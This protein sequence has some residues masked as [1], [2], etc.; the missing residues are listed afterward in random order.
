MV[1][2][3]LCRARLVCIT[4]DW[5]VHCTRRACDKFFVENANFRETLQTISGS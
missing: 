3:A 5:A 4:W 2:R 1:R